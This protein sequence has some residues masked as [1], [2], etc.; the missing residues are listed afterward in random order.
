VRS[1]PPV[2]AL[3]LVLLAVSGCGGTP[4]STQPTSYSHAFELAFR[5]S[6]SCSSLS[7]TMPSTIS[8]QLGARF[9][10]LGAE[11][12]IQT[13]RLGG[14]TS[15]LIVSLKGSTQ[16]TGRIDGTG[17][18][19]D[20]LGHPVQF[21]SSASIA[22]SGTPT[23]GYNLVLSGIAS[24]CSSFVSGTLVCIPFVPCTASDH[25]AVLKPQ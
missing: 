12:F 23:Q 14:N 18:G 9:D 20:E 16:V 17:L 15:A 2:I 22:G 5:L 3:V 13:G 7:S 4:T 21:S 6:A 11:S 19:Q 25:S 10:S 1:A 8:I 24:Y